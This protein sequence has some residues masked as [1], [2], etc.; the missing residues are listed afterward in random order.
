MRT[1]TANTLRLS[2]SYDDLHTLPEETARAYALESMEVKGHNVYFVDFDNHLGYSCLVYRSGRILPY[3]ADHALHHR[4]MW[5]SALRALYRKELRQRLYTDDELA[6]PLQDYDDYRRRVDY[7]V[8]HYGCQ[9]D[10]VSLFYSKGV[11]AG[12]DE[13][14]KEQAR[15][16]KLIQGKTFDPIAHGWF[17]DKDFVLRHCRLYNAVE[18]RREEM[19]DDFS[20][21][22]GAFMYEMANHEYAINWQGNWD[23]LSCFGKIEYDH[24]NDDQD[25]NY[26]F[27]QLNFTQT[28]RSAYHAARAAY[29]KQHG[30]DY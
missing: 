10:Y 4:D 2:C 30:D 12:S 28:Q 23:V 8:N 29:F 26:Y 7:L 3:A 18:K 5:R 13:E 9:R 20:F 17:D 11:V 25:L 22:V 15:I 21:N 24:K 16:E 27:D 19:K 6:S 1:N 14:K